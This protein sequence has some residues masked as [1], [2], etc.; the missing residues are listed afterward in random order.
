MNLILILDQSGSM[1]AIRDDVTGTL[2]SLARE[3]AGV[4][5]TVIT[6][7][8]QA[9][10]AY[11][12]PGAGLSDLR[13]LPG[14]GTALYDAVAAALPHVAKDTLMVI[15][16][17]GQENASTKWT[18][19]Q[20]GALLPALERQGMGLA[21][22]G[23]NFDAFAEGARLGVQAASTRGYVTTAALGQNLRGDVLRATSQYATTGTVTFKGD[24]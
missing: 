22:L 7:D 12:G 13:Y 8:T 5:T 15:V 23:A 1:A 19:E 4:Q 14:G 11:Q 21:F 18:R 17:D 9:R 3:H 24:E 20:I 10:V 6:F 2:T 16:T